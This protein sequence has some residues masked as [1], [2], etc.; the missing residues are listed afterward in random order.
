MPMK[1]VAVVS[2]VSVISHGPLLEVHCGKIYFGLIFH[3]RETLNLKLTYKTRG[4]SD[5][6]EQ[7]IK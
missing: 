2:L 3:P 5:I 4:K 7:E 6:E 1:P